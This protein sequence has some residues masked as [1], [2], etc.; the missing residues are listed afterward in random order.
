M[1]FNYQYTSIAYTILYCVYNLHCLYQSKTIKYNVLLSEPTSFIILSL[2]LSLHVYLVSLCV[3]YG[4]YN[5][6]V[7][8]R[9]AHGVQLITVAWK[10]SGRSGL[11]VFR[12]N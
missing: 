2:V 4:M 9:A 8:Q 5:K 3:R 12:V 6:A 1:Y 7:S 11:L 10:H